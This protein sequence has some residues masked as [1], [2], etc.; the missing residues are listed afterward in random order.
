MLFLGGQWVKAAPAF[1]IEMCEKFH[2]HPTEFDGTD[3]AIFQEYDMK[4]RRHMEYVRDHGCWSD[5]PFEKVM[6]DFRA[7]YPAEAYKS[8]D[9]GE[10]FEDG[11]R[12]D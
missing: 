4:N 9:P 3:N 8:F 11:M 7:F 2:V 6:A 5:F 10:L 1:N 12:I